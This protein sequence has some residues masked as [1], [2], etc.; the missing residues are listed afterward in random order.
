MTNSPRADKPNAICFLGGRSIEAVLFLVRFFH[1]R[2]VV[3]YAV[4][5][6]TGAEF[7]A[8]VVHGCKAETEHVVSAG[9]GYLATTALMGHCFLSPGAEQSQVVA[10]VAGEWRNNRRC[11]DWASSSALRLKLYTS[12]TLQS[13]VFRPELG[14]WVFPLEKWL[15]V[16]PIIKSNLGRVPTLSR[17]SH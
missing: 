1:V 12:P 16:A 13:T 9:C 4:Q 17:G 10:D 7:I 15:P 6:H 11:H 2:T 3:V 14:Y 5:R 8:E